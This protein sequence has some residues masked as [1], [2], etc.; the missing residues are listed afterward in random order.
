MTPRDC[1]LALTIPLTRRR[2]LDDLSQGRKDF[3][4]HIKRSNLELSV[5]DEYYWDSVYGP[6]S[7]TVQRICKEV[8]AL[9]V[10]VL[11][12]ANP[13]DLSEL[14]SKFKVITFVSHWRFTNLEPEEV[15]N[16]V[17]L[18]DAL[19]SPRNSVQK[20]ISRTFSERCPELLDPT[21]TQQVSPELLRQKFV[22]IVRPIIRS[23]H[24]LYKKGTG[25][26]TE[27]VELVTRPLERLTRVAFEQAY[28]AHITAGRSI[29]F[30]DGMHTVEE[31][32]GTVPET[33]CG[34]LDLTICN[35]V[36]VGEVIKHFH[37]D[38][39][40][41]VN[42]YPTELHVRMVFYKLAINALR[43]RPAPFI[44][45]LTNIHTRK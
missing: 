26:H 13:R 5:D 10:T 24:A 45:V 9:G 40:V 43:W 33:F 31:L 44:D 39:R 35:S 17:G 23:A 42:R 28:P 4:A 18:M 14:F 2:F 27:N 12:I 16:V 7:N 21:V 32:A 29:E 19:R 22:E 30:I 11:E 25:E 38:C 1:A 37:P 15:L 3:A 20:A 41:A 34:I 6:I 36:I 8:D